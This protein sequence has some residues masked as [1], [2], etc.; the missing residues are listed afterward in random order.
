MRVPAI[1]SLFSGIGGLDLAVEAATGGR[2][3]WQAEVNPWRRSVLARHWPHV[4]RFEDVREIRG[5]ERKPEIIC[6]GFPCQDIS[7]AGRREGI[8]GPK[9]GLWSEFA[10]II[11][12]LGPRIVIVENVAA[13]TVR[14]LDRVLGD[15]ASIGFDAEWSSLRA[16]DAG[17]THRRRRTFIVALADA[18]RE[19]REPESPAWAGSRIT[20]RDDA[21]RRHGPMGWPPPPA[22]VGGWERWISA[23]GPSPG[24]RRGPDGTADRLDWMRR[25]SALGDSVVP[26][27]AEQAIRGLLARF[28]RGP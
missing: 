12:A 3:I 19:R 18:D 27:Q 22:D 24:V 6:G 9:S 17:A 11:R 7:G 10:R 20:H 5:H 23:G 13:L 1:G 25:I 8:C 2:V 26:A 21:P 14:G 16:S 28:K 15:L 4:K